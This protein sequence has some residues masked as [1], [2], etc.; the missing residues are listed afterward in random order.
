M[1]IKKEV[2]Y[3]EEAHD[4]DF[5]ICI[6]DDSCDGESNS[7]AGKLSQ[8][9]DLVV[10]KLEESAKINKRKSTKQIDAIPLIPAKK[11]RRNSTSTKVEKRDSTKTCMV[12]G[13]KTTSKPTTIV[14][15]ESKIEPSPIAQS[16][17]PIAHSSKTSG[18]PIAKNGK[19][20]NVD[21]FDPFAKRSEKPKIR[22]EDALASDP[23]NT[24]LKPKKTRIAHVP[25]PC[26]SSRELISILRKGNRGDKKRLHRVRFS[27]APDNVREYEPNDDED[28]EILIAL[29]TKPIRSVQANSTQAVQ[30][31]S[32]E[33]DPLHEIITDITEWK[34]E[35]LTQRNDQP[36]I[37]GV[38]LVVYPLIDTYTS[39][40]FYK[41]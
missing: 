21:R 8:D 26:T 39:F 37:N 12:T 27:E 40:E 9:Q 29:P 31:N 30:A 25:K 16:I 33:N 23:I 38:N 10:K 6:S 19:L 20:E 2:S 34:P 36:P 14:K 11:A 18:L 32:F 7:W 35:W 24:V 5:T 15:K 28:Y 13:H 22:F 3:S 17:Q 41:K 4:D 1:E